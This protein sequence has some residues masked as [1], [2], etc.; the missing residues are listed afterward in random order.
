MS[1]L[2]D[3]EALL[4]VINHSFII[5]ILKMN[6]RPEHEAVLKIRKIIMDMPTAFKREES[7]MG[8]LISREDLLGT[9]R[10]LMT[11]VIKN[12]P[13]AKFVLEQVLFDIE[14]ADTA[15]DKEK[16]IK[17]LKALKMMCFL[18]IAN[19]GDEK[20]DCAYINVGNAL[21]KAIEIVEE[22]GTE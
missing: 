13:A 5:P 8:D 17:E 20:L 15:F 4:E 1:D 22:G 6:L 14:H 21:D 10:L 11:D 12:N 9:Q 3:R 2:I 18:T 19:T 7:R 16:V